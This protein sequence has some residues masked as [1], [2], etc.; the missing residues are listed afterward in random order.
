MD[1]TYQVLRLTS[2]FYNAYPKT[3]YPELLTKNGRAY[4][5]LLLDLHYDYFIAVPFRTEIRH[6]YAY[7][8]TCSTR[9]RLHQS[10]LDYSKI[11]IIQ[12]PEYISEHSAVVDSDEYHEAKAHIKRIVLE[13]NQYIAGY[14][15]SVEKNDWRKLKRVYTFSTLPY[16]H[17]ELNIHIT[18]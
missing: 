3:Q 15:K 14:I 2:A 10:G 8:F 4:T 6:K 18:K 17:K 12:N 1:F 5:C 11:A 9:S 13:S 16:F 7:K